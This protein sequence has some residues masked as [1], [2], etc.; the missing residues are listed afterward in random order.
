MAKTKKNMQICLASATTPKEATIA[1]KA[2]GAQLQTCLNT[3]VNDLESP[4]KEQWQGAIKGM[5]TALASIP[6]VDEKSVSEEVTKA[7]VAISGVAQTAI[8]N[9]EGIAKD[10]GAKLQTTLASIPG[11]I[12]SAIALKL[13]DGSLITKEV[14]A[15]SIAD[16][17]SAASKAAHDSALVEVTRI[18]NHRMVLTTASLPVPADEILVKDDAAFEVQKLVAARRVEQLKP[19]GLPADRVLTLAWNAEETAY[20]DTVSLMT[21]AAASAAKPAAGAN[22]FINR[23]GAEQQPPKRHTA[24]AGIC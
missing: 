17:T 13:K 10:A 19:F 9:A 4:L 11:Q 7:L 14:S 8:T 20:N 18:G 1:L 24:S 2:A 3:V 16:A 12:E 5:E 21:A 15:Q 23:P 22:P 6:E